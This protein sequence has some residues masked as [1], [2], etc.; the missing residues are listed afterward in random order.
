VEGGVKTGFNV[1]EIAVVVSEALLG[2][3]F[4]INAEE[5]VKVKE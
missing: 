2:K 4:L 1:N 5:A 3:I